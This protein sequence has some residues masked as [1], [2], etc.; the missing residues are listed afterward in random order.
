MDLKD[1]IGVSE[2]VRNTKVFLDTAENDK[3][4]YIRRGDNVFK[5]THLPTRVIYSDDHPENPVNKK[6]KQLV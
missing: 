5:L 3:P 4:V 6:A 1:I 2:F